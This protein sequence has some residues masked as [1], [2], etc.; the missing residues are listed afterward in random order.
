MTLAVRAPRHDHRHLLRTGRAEDVDVNRHT[1][2]Q[3]NGDVLLEYDVDRQGPELRRDSEP[4]LQGASTW[5]ELGQHA[6]PGGR[7]RVGRDEYLLVIA[8]GELPHCLASP[9]PGSCV[10]ASV[11]PCGAKLNTR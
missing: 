7:Q 1:V 10:G 5:I 4:R 2:P 8:H 6:G 9:P 3:L 11:R